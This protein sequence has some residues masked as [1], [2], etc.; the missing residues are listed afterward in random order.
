[1]YLLRKS[2][3][4]NQ[5]KRKKYENINLYCLFVNQ[6]IAIERAEKNETKKKKNHN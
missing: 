4:K 6:I 5:K 1:M 2:R 3:K